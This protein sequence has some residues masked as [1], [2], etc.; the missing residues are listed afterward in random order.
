ML[1]TYYGQ[2][3]GV[4]EVETKWKP[5]KALETKLAYGTSS[6]EHPGEV[7]GLWSFQCF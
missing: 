5:N 4:M 3:L 1:L 7:L 6:L 2:S